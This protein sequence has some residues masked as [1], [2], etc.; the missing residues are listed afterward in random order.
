MCML[1]ALSIEW[2][3]HQENWVTCTVRANVSHGKSEFSLIQGGEE[4]HVRKW[5]KLLCQYRQLP[6]LEIHTKERNL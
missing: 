2:D 4:C 1:N 3:W 6:S 5:P